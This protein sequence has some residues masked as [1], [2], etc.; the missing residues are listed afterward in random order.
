MPEA[1]RSPPDLVLC[2]LMMPGVDGFGVL[3]RL[4]AEPTTS[5]VPFVFLTA[6]QCLRIR[7]SDSSLGQ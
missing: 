1:L 7:L 4:R 5:G 2:D 3:A 6:R